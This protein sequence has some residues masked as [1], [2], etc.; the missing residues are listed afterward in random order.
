MQLITFN[1]DRGIK[2]GAQFDEWAIDLQRALDYLPAGDYS[3]DSNALDRG[4]TPG[5]LSE[6]GDDDS[7]MMEGIQQT[8][9]AIQDSLP[10]ATDLLISKGILLKVDQL[11]IKPPL[12]NPGKIICVGMNYPSPGSGEFQQPEYPVLFLKSS[13]TLTGHRQPIVL[14]HI[15]DKIF[16]EGELAVVIGKR[17][18][19]I[20]I[21]NTLS[22]IAGFTI[23]NDVGA[24]DLEQRTS[25]WAT[26]KL[27]DTFCP[28][29][30][31]LVTAD[32][33]P[34]PKRLSIRTLINGKLVQSGKT[35]E[36]IFS[37]P[38]L[39]NYISSIAT[40]YPGDIILTGSP[41]SINGLPAPMVYL[42]PGD[43]ITIEIDGIGVLSNQT[44]EEEY[45]NA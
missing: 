38:K 14:P 39:I 15:S 20:S 22:Y 23:A 41:K 3:I 37:V 18:K 8:I 26:G 44:V 2:L 1:D 24:R 27:S 11:T 32:E 9:E 12:I 29:G 28:L 10:S 40:L 45:Q 34:D 42:K 33:I 13:S 36:M 4:I 7:L 6:L 30:P 19:H 16:C 31:A 25:Q 21:E 35:S 17:G 43:K 5:F